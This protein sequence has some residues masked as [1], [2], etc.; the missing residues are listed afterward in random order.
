MGFLKAIIRAVRIL[1][2][3]VVSSKHVSVSTNKDDANDIGMS[4]TYWI[5][6]LTVKISRFHRN[7]NDP[8]RDK[9]NQAFEIMASP[10]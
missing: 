7:I 6:I 10:E 3:I 8:D 2:R 4:Q 9:N 1:G 5:V